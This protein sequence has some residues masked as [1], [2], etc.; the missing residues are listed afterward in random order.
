MKA[1][2]MGAA[3]RLTDIPN[4]G[5]S[6]AADLASIGIKEPHDLIMKEPHDLYVL[7]SAATGRRQDPCVLDTF[8]AAVDFMNGGDARP[9]WHFTPLRKRQY[10]DL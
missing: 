5:P 3:K 7:L 8:M 4:I 2:M 6:I 9:W 1:K 10:P